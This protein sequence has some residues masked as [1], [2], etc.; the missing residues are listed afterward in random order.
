MSNDVVTGRRGRTALVLAVGGSALAVATWVGG[1]HGLA[2]GLAVFY[3]VATLIAYLWS[4]RDSDVAA[5]MRDGGDERQRRLDHDATALAGLAMGITAFVG[6]VIS[7]AVNEGNIGP[8]G[9]ICAVGGATYV[10]SLI[11]FRRRS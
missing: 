9:L 10:V 4:G 6:A 8:F 1:E 11:V 7:A 2:V 5:I 3:A